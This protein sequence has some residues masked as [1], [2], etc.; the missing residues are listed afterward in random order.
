MATLITQ[1][2]KLQVNYEG[3][4]VYVMNVSFNGIVGSIQSAKIKVFMPNIIQYTLGD[5]HKPIKNIIQE[6]VVGG[7]LITF[8]FGE[9]K[10]L[11]ISARLS[12]G[13]QFTLATSIGT[14][15][16]CEPQLW[17]NDALYDTSVVDAVTLRVVPQFQIES[18]LLLPTVQPA[19]GGTVI[20]SLELENFGDKGVE[21]SNIVITCP[22]PE[23]LT[24]DPNFIVKG[25]DISW[26][27]FQDVRSDGIE[28]V[29]ANNILSFSIPYYKGYEYEIIYSATISSDVPIGSQMITN[30]SWTLEGVEQLSGGNIITLAAPIYHGTISKYGPDYTLAGEY[31][32]YQLYLINDGSQALQNVNFV[33]EL[34]NQVTCYRFQTGTFYIAAINRN[35]NG[36]Y[37][38]AYTTLNG[39]NGT[40]GPF[41]TDINTSI[42]LTTLIP[43]GDQLSSLSWVLPVLGLGVTQKIPPSIDGVVKPE[44]AKGTRILN[45]FH[46]DWDTPTGRQSNV[47]NQTAVVDDLCVLYPLFVEISPNKPVNP[48]DIIKYRLT[49][50]CSKSR[51]QNPFI[52]TLLPPTVEFVNYT[53]AVYTDYFPN[54]QP[55]PSPPVIILENFKNTGK[56][57][58]KA[59]FEGAYSFNC[60]QR[61]TLVIEFEVRVAIG[62]KGSTMVNIVLNN[63]LNTGVIPSG[64]EVYKDHLDI[65]QNG[66]IDELYA[67]SPTL[68]NIILFFASTSSNKKVKG[69]LDIAY[70]EEPEIGRTTEGGLIEYILSVTNVGN[71]DLRSVEIVDILPHIGDTGVIEVQEQRLSEYVVYNMN[72]ISATIT[73]LL[74]NQL[75]PKLTIAYSKS[76]NPVRFGGNFEEIGADNDWSSV[77]PPV[78]TD[79][80]SFKVS[81]QNTV[82]SPAQ[83]ITIKVQGVAPVGVTPNKVAWNSFAAKVSYIDLKGSI[84]YLLAVEPEKV[85]V[86][87]IDLPPGTGKIGGI[88]FI[89]N[90]ENGIYET[91]DIGVNDIGVIL[92]GEDMRAV[93]AI[94]T[95]PDVNG[96]PGYYLFNNLPK[97]KYYIRVLIDEPEYKFT[98]QRLDVPNG[99][100]PYPSTGV[101]PII[102]LN[103]QEVQ[104]DNDA[105]MVKRTQES[106]L[107]LVLQMNES[108]HKMLRNVTY[109][110]LLLD[111][112]FEDT[113][114]LI[115]T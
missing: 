14:S 89:D 75:E 113:I 1:V 80:K 78:S 3:V 98:I 69:A 44:T 31:I 19:P 9:I 96:N 99:S 36:Q 94:F 48:G 37:N 45:H 70:S 72:N 100:K 23:G 40:L 38:I 53:Q 65:A 86:Q 29:I 87:I 82:L 76:Y 22:M 7:K 93:Q 112:K 8:D 52:A 10:D 103:R 27:P 20:F 26:P 107:D 6:T 12:I 67:Q 30:I 58:I 16:T 106:Q 39:Q 41:N 91:G 73:P 115:R 101:T 64:V 92:Y 32:N 85:G 109:N 34:P 17:I 15:F 18:S 13:C 42:D 81:T 59:A 47:S 56:T 95:A 5:A 77:L 60:R 63:T 24:L 104:L 25:K 102:D 43:V 62:A 50:D 84:Q 83:T 51:L 54:P 114:N 28:G 66:R 88:V 55:L 79:L 61:S 110:Q 105:G 11:G 4:F 71:A 33:D 111:M 97:G 57:L 90:N 46:L 49:I 74:P 35:L 21:I 108:A 68:S 2:D